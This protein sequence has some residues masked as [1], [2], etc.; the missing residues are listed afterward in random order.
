MLKSGVKF[1]KGKFILYVNQYQHA[2]G[3]ANGQSG[4]TNERSGFVFSQASESHFKIILKQ[5]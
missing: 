2:A 3:H 4:D 5:V 1:I